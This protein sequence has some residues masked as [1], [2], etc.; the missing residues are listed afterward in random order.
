MDVVRKHVQKLRGRIDIQSET[1]L[2]TTFFLR[3]PLTLAIIEG[4]VIAVGDD[5]YIV[6]LY[7]VLEIFCPSESQVWRE[8]GELETV[9]LRGV[10]LPV[11]RLHQRFDVTPRSRTLSDGVLI[12][13]ETGNKRFLH[14]RGRDARQ[15]GARRQEP[16]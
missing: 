11:V 3:L 14:L 2:G 7:S 13:T 4:L 16:G 12:V 6:P 10:E 5:R 8:H 15:T 9:T 1:G